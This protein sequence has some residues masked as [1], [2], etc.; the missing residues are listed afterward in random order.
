M[1]MLRR[2]D[3]RY[4]TTLAKCAP[5]PGPE[6]E[7]GL[8]G[9]QEDEAPSAAVVAVGNA[10]ETEPSTCT[11]AASERAADAG[12]DA[13]RSGA[14]AAVKARDGERGALPNNVPLSCSFSL[15]LLAAVSVT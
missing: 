7:D 10:R 5:A 12:K 3:S 2:C 11:A 6:A 15:S 9:G 14:A 13:W 8:G 4:C 1:L